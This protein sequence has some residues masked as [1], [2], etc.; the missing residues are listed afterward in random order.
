MINLGLHDSQL[1][2]TIWLVGGIVIATIVYLLFAYPKFRRQRFTHL[3]AYKKTGAVSAAAVMLL[4][5]WSAKLYYYDRFYAYELNDSSLTLYHP[6]QK[7]VNINLQALRG[8][9]TE[10]EYSSKTPW[11]G[12]QAIV[13]TQTGRQ[14]RSILSPE[15]SSI[16]EM[17]NKLRNAPAND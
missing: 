17:C 13:E 2:L 3:E 4:F 16:R 12:T 6:R 10:R 5:L 11:S 7:P 14:Y 15:S 1:D 8:C 9:R